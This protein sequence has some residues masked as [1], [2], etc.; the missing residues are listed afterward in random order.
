LKEA[1]TATDWFQEAETASPVTDLHLLAALADA[2]FK[3]GKRE[4][5]RATIAR[6][7]DKDPQNLELLAV[8]RKMGAPAA[9]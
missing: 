9:Q 1:E 8:K 5:S 7:L 3:A 2:Q 4:A 6:G